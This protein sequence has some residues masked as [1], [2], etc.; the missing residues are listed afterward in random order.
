MLSLYWFALIVGGGMLL[1]SLLGDLFGDVLGGHDADVGFGG[2]DVELGAGGHEIELSTS[3]AQGDVALGAHA[4]THAPGMAE[5]TGASSPG[6]D[7]QATRILSLR[8]ITYFLFGFGATGLLLSR[9]APD[10]SRLLAAA[11]S[12]TCGVLAAGI[13]IAVFGWVRSTEAGER[14]SESSFIGLAA[15]VVLPVDPTRSGRIRVRRG[16]REYELRARPFGSDP[17]ASDV[18]SDVVIV[19]MHEG[20]ALVA[21]FDSPAE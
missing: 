7:V 10:A 20:T 18:G 13:S 16:E 6:P 3:G 8:T 9:F 17:V 4:L 12:G 2:H 19:E 14:E 15:T 5:S 11:A 21:P 1:V